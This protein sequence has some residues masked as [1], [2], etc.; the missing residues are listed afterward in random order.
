[1][2]KIKKQFFGFHGIF[3]I[4]KMHE[5]PKNL[6]QFNEI[7]GFNS[8]MLAPNDLPII[9]LPLPSVTWLLDGTKLLALSDDAICGFS[10]S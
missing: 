7:D 3:G 9:E 5:N 4:L 2:H 10:S 1:M 8:S 6:I